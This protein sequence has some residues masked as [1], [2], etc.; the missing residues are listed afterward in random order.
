LLVV[1][2]FFQY[3]YGLKKDL[4]FWETLALGVTVLEYALQIYK[5]GNLFITSELL[6]KY[7]WYVMM[8]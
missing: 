8:A 3:I 4:S 6:E 2:I 1:G 5:K 7:K